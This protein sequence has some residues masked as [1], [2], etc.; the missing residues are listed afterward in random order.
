MVLGRQSNET[1][2]ELAHPA[3]S[4]VKVYVRALLPPDAVTLRKVVELT[5]I[6]FGEAEKDE[7]ESGTEFTVRLVTEEV[8]WPAV[9][10]AKTRM[11][12]TP[13]TLGVHVREVTFLVEHPV[14]SPVYA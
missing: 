4:P 7:M 13:Q 9:S 3:G 8:V 14:G 5:V 12:N 2:L 6:G 10:F 11:E 1:A